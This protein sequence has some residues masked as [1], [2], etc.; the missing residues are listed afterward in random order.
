ML[1]KVLRT[2]LDSISNPRCNYVYLCMVEV[3]T[4]LRGAGIQERN[5]AST[6]KRMLGKISWQPF[7]VRKGKKLVIS[8]SIRW[9]HACVNT[10]DTQPPE[11][12]QKPFPLFF[13]FDLCIE[14]SMQVW[15]CKDRRRCQIPCNWTYTYLWVTWC[16]YWKLN[17]GPVEKHQALLTTEPPGS[18]GF[19]PPCSR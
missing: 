16:R 1:L 17:S 7:E 4:G 11:L 5:T 2:S 6:S 3:K 13:C 15:V 12:W 18:H 10:L 19:K 8:E 9:S 14:A